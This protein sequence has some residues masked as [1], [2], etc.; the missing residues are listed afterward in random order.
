MA[1]GFKTWWI[2]HGLTAYFNKYATCPPST[3][4][5]RLY[6]KHP[7]RLSNK[8]QVRLAA[9][10]R[11]P[12]LPQDRRTSPASAGATVCQLSRRF[13]RLIIL[14]R[15]QLTNQSNRDVS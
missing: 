8:I 6:R 10:V 12:P 3:T 5:A 13:R 14:C 1:S 4:V 11:M 9:E 15:T 7:D 2:V